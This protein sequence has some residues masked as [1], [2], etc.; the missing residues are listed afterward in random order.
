ME[1]LKILVLYGL[2]DDFRI[3]RNFALA[4]AT[5]NHDQVVAFYLIKEKKFDKQEAQKWWVNKSLQEFKKK[6]QY[7]ISLE[8]IRTNSYKNFLINYLPKKIFLFIGI[9]PMNPNI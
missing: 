7:N 1:W 2:K 5:K 8:I 9:K 4:E 6:L 3:K